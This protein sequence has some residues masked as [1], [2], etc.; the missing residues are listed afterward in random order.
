LIAIA[1]A[2][3]GQ[4]K[5]LI[6]TPGEGEAFQGNQ[7]LIASSKAQRDLRLMGRRDPNLPL[8]QSAEFSI[9]RLDAG[10]GKFHDSLLRFF[11]LRQ[12]ELDRLCWP[13]GWRPPPHLA[14]D[15]G[16]GRFCPVVIPREEIP[17]NDFLVI[18]SATSFVSIDAW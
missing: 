14:M 8:P 1:A 13:C 6:S 5:T 17:E 18:R 9:P 15:V 3:H 12:S 10:F 2:W 7:E 11:L 16:V 4:I